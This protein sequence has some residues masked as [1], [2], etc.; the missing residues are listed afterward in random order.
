MERRFVIRYYAIFVGPIVEISGRILLI[1]T[2]TAENQRVDAV[3][4]RYRRTNENALTVETDTGRVRK[5]TFT[6]P[7]IFVFDTFAVDYSW[8][9][10]L[11]VSKLY[12]GVG[13][14]T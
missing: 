2:V 1:R 3:F 7:L 11:D 13:E 4:N 8:T 14:P 6:Q 12:R 10:H 9:V 5:I